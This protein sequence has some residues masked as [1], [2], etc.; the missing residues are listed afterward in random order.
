[1]RSNSST[2]SLVLLALVT[3]LA[4]ADDISEQDIPELNIPTGV[5][6]RY[7]MDSQGKVL[8]HGYLGETAQ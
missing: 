1:M 5:P 3:P 6:M 7:V 4:C 2:R 8:E